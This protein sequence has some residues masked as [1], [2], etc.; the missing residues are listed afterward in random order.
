MKGFKAFDKDLKCRGLQYTIGG[1][2]SF[3]GKPIPCEQGFH[4]CRTIADTYRYYPPMDDTRICE[5]EA[6]GDT[7]TDDNIKFCTNKIVVL[8]EITD[9]VQKHCNADGTVNGYCNTGNYNT[10]NRNTGDRNTG[11][12]T[13]GTG[14]QGTGTQGTGTQG[15]GT[16]GTVTQGTI[17]QGTGTQGTGTQGTGTQGT[18]TQGTVTQGTITQGTGTQGTGTQG[19]GTQGAGTQ[20]TGTQGTVTQVAG[21]QGTGIVQIGH[22][23]FSELK[24]KKFSFLMR[25][26]IGHMTIGVIQEHLMCFIICQQQW[27][28]GFLNQ[29]CLTKRKKSI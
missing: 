22:L 21:T 13:Q 28:H 16:Q 1:E 5:V 8:R 25:I 19:A 3:D 20:G 23:E 11:N 14:T 24:T 6:I 15:T 2:M 27:L 29:I 17:T 12:R 10:G 26:P 9:K 18:G 4:F 7:E